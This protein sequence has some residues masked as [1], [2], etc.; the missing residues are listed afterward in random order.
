MRSKPKRF[1]ISLS[2]GDYRK[3]SK[4]GRGHKP[5]LSLQYLVSWSIQNGLLERANE[6][7]LHA[8]LANPLK[9]NNSND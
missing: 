6:P 3:L 5:V 4:I 7:K 8:E 2:K 9:P 1:S